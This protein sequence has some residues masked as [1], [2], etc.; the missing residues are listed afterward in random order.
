MSSELSYEAGRRSPPRIL[1]RAVIWAGLL[2][3]ICIIALDI[4]SPQNWPP[5][6]LQ[7]KRQRE[8]VAARVDAAGGWTVL[9]RACAMLVETNKSNIFTYRAFWQ[10]TNEL[11]GL[12]RVLQPQEVR[13]YSPDIVSNDLNV[14]I[15]RI[16]IFG[17]HSTGGNSFPY[18]GLE[19]VFGSNAHRYRP[20]PSDGGASGNGY[21]RFRP[22]TNNIYEIF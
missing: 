20:S 17:I 12:L 19:F 6:W 21:S 9:E 13:F 8:A 22:I 4:F 3:L 2:V 7:R 5:N 18:Y 15:V 11:D 14:A 16:K 10:R 1:G